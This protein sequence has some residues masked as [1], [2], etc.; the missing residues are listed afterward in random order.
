MNW[1]DAY[2]NLQAKREL[3]LFQIRRCKSELKRWSSDTFKGGDLA[4]N[5]DA[6]T[7]LSNTERIQTEIH[8]HKERLAVI[9]QE[10]DELDSIINKF[11]GLDNKI[12]YLRIVK[13]HSL[14]EI[15][16]ELGY[17]YEYI[18]NRS[19][20]ISKAIKEVTFM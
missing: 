5:A 16:N 2:Q 9:N 13:G 14:N 18:K 12:A 11:T 8:I 10:I 1:I 7:S 17:S 15:A 6:V 3:E 20:N 4:K 19:M